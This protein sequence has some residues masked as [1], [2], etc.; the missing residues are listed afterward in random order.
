MQLETMQLK[1]MQLARWISFLLVFPSAAFAQ[2]TFSCPANQ[3][4]TTQLVNTGQACA[5]LPAVLSQ[6]TTGTAA[7]VTGV[8]APVN[9]GRIV[10]TQTAGTGGVTLNTFVATD[11]SAPTKFITAPSGSCGSGVALA[12]AAAGVT[13][14]LSGYDGTMQVVADSGGVTAGHLVVGS[15]VTPG[16]AMDSGQTSSL[17][18]SEKTMVCGT[19]MNTVAGG[20]LVTIN[21]RSR[22]S[23]GHLVDNIG[24]TLLAPLGTGMLK[25]AAGV[26]SVGVAGTDF[27]APITLTTTGT[28]G[29]ATFSAGALN[30]PQY[31]GGGSSAGSIMGWTMGAVAL[32]STATYMPYSATT[33][34]L[35]NEGRL[36]FPSPVAGTAKNL[37]FWASSASPTQPAT[38]ALVCTL[39][40]NATN[41]ALTVTFAAGTTY[42]TVQ[43]DTTH[44]VSIAVGDLL[45]LA[46]ANAATAASLSIASASM[47]IQ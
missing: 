14:P 31:S 23:F 33:T 45:D 5:G 38:G 43:T 47:A 41:T 17:L 2:S 12:T 29:A 3:Y 15:T 22:G 18:I 20:A 30:I 32:S 7:N 36:Q 40:K 4:V 10:N 8:V 42:T 46:C 44:T 37:T 9:G 25:V 21:P 27:Q 13:F 1:T 19:A 26:P 6:N 24:G 16:D 35:A 11:T 28:S 39:R 34:S